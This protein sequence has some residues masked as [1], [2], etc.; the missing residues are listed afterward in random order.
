MSREKATLYRVQKLDELL[1][2][3]ARYHRFQFDRHAHEELSLGLM[4]EG[5]QKYHCRGM[6]NHAPRAAHHRQPR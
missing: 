1:V 6:N 5:V 3:Q 2:F 4:E